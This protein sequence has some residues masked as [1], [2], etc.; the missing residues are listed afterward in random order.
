M[1]M[2]KT[3][4]TLPIVYPKITNSTWMALAFYQVAE[5]LG[6]DYPKEDCVDF[7]SEKCV[8]VISQ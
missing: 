7:F 5:V 4:Q 6:E 1:L 3:G 8:Y 2:L